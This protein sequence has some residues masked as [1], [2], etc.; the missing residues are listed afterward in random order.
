MNVADNAYPLTLE[1]WDSS[2]NKFVAVSAHL[3]QNILLKYYFI[4]GRVYSHTTQYKRA[5]HFQVS[6]MHVLQLLF[7]YAVFQNNC[8]VP[9]SS[10]SLR[11][12]SQKELLP[13]L[14]ILICHEHRNHDAFYFRLNITIKDQ[15][16]FQTN[17]A[18]TI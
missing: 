13:S 1:T 3:K 10:F 6:R 15:A 18:T 12:A 4:W 8:H 2:M 14:F 11:I 16:L 17:Q 7:G 5:Q 9:L